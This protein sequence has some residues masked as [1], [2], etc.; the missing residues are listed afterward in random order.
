MNGKQVIVVAVDGPAASGKST[1]SRAV[2]RTL[3]FNYVDS[4]AMYRTVTW[5]ALEAGV[6]AEDPIAVVAMLRALKVHFKLADG[7]VRML[8]EGVYPDK[9]IRDP[10]V[11][12]KV[13]I[14]AAIPGVRQILVRYQRSLTE[15]GSMV[16]EG[17]DIGSVV[18]PDT[19]HKFYLDANPNV[20]AHR[21][22][23]DLEAMRVQ[24][25]QAGVAQELQRRDKLDSTRQTAPLQV[26][27]GAT[28]VD[29]SEQSVDA[30]AKI[31]V[32]HIRQQ[33][34]GLRS[35]GGAGFRRGSVGVKA[36]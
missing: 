27:P 4:G 22:A 2:A 20:R 21:R 30:T 23:R 18:F 6:N 9:A 32:D 26:A 34:S 25:N 16:M 33:S 10:R 15:F 12:E 8:I 17:R 31:I 28:I 13:S 24:A 11:T 14:V 35:F 29:N 7:E 5:K 19:P 3:G 36:D 1:V